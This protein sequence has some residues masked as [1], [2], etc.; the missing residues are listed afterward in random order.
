MN[1]SFTMILQLSADTPA[2]LRACDVERLIEQAHGIPS[3]RA[4]GEWL[5]DARP[6]L[7]EQIEAAIEDVYRQSNLPA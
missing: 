2:Q 4:F 3:T 1:R 6:D 5:I 7:E